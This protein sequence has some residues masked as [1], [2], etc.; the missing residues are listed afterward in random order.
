MNRDHHNRSR[1][2][3]GLGVAAGALTGLYI[4]L[5]RRHVAALPDVAPAE[6]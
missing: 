3:L 2:W 5:R 4:W 1:F 6:A